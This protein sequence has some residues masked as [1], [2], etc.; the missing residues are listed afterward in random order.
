M[1]LY[2]TDAAKH[3]KTAGEDP[4]GLDGQDGQDEDLFVRYVDPFATANI[5]R[6][7]F[8][9]YCVPKPWVQFHV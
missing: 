6:T 4:D 2:Y 1:V 5:F 7:L 8:F 3:K 9:K